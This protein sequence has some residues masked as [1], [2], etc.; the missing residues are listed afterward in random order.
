MKITLT[1][2]LCHTTFIGASSYR[3]YCSSCKRNR[4]SEISRIVAD[5]HRHKCPD[6]SNRISKEAERCVSCARKALRKTVE[7]HCSLC[8]GRFL[9]ISWRQAVGARVIFCPS[10]KT[11][12]TSEVNRIA[13]AARK[14]R[15]SKSSMRG[16]DRRLMRLIAEAQNSVK[17]V[18]DREK[19]IGR[20]PANLLAQYPAL[21]TDGTVPSTVPPPRRSHHKVRV[22]RTHCAKGHELTEANTV[23]QNRGRVCRTCLNEK[24]RQAYRAAHPKVLSISQFIE[25]R[26]AQVASYGTH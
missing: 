5:R 1:C 24:A 9:P 12:R 14:P 11:N 20:I 17:V 2:D 7:V 4:A 15:G 13:W 23:L 8:S 3:R 10:C 18:F 6:C 22:R 19:G 21:A 25:K 16:T 26:A